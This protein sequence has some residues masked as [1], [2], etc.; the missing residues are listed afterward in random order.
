MKIYSSGIIIF[1]EGLLPTYL[2]D[3]TCL[4]KIP[5][6]L[7]FPLP[8]QPLDFL[9]LPAVPPLR[10]ETEFLQPRYQPFLKSDGAG[11]T[12]L[13][14][15][16]AALVVVEFVVTLAQI[17]GFVVAVLRTAVGQLAA[18]WKLVVWFVSHFLHRSLS[19]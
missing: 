8:L 11:L 13:L 7:H 9:P 3:A 12:S 1:S 5:H 19:L 18:G 15:L 14:R 17:V 4:S 6:M 10:P 16:A 2:N